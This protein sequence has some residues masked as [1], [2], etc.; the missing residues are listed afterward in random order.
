MQPRSGRSSSAQCELSDLTN[1]HHLRQ[2]LFISQALVHVVHVFLRMLCRCSRFLAPIGLNC[3]GFWSHP[4]TRRP[5]DWTDASWTNIEK[6]PSQKAQG[7][8]SLDPVAQFGPTRRRRGKGPTRRRAG[9]R[10]DQPPRVDRPNA[11]VTESPH[12]GASTVELNAGKPLK[13][14]QHLATI[15]L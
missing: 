12:V 4:E 15:Y 5:N 3:A 7:A 11:G 1:T 10:A 8:P 6:T 9:R 2:L 13:R 14:W